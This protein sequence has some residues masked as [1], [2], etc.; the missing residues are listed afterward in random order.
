MVHGR[1]VEALLGVQAEIERAGGK[2][3]SITPIGLLVGLVLALSLWALALLGAC[4]SV[5]PILVIMAVLLGMIIPSRFSSSPCSRYS[6]Y[7]Q[8]PS[9]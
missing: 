1:D 8:Y 7:P 4:A 5:Y 6:Q 9:R 3:L 2:A